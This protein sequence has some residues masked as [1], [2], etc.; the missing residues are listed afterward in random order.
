M[1]I[2]VNENSAV[3]R[4]LHEQF[5]RVIFVL[6]TAY[7][8]TFTS[9]FYKHLKKI[10]IVILASHGKYQGTSHTNTHF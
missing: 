3:T 4:K 7:L 10:L 6:I 8:C 9:R 5:N 1:L 2:W